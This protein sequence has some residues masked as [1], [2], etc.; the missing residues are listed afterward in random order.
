VHTRRGARAW[1]YVDDAGRP[2]A[3]ETFA[4]VRASV[5]DA[6]EFVTEALERWGL[7]DVAEAELVVSELASNAILHA[8][9]EAFRVTLRHLGDGVK[10][11][12]FDFS[13]DMPAL[14]SVG[15]DDV[16]GRGLVLV[17]AVSR[18]WG[19]DRLPWG[20]RVWAEVE[21]GETCV[22]CGTGRQPDEGPMWAT[23]NSQ[24][25]Y[26]AVVLALLGTL[27]CGVMSG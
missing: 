2:V 16:H 3:T 15:V 4:R 10:V 20:K 14:V 27:A 25:L 13:R 1:A 9:R 12:V 6:R 21:R 23:R 7:E 24:V 19:T 5:A 11:E 8:R 26:V 17:N 22:P 18:A